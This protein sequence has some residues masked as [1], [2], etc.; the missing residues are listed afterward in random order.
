[1]R[2]TNYSSTRIRHR[3]PARRLPHRLALFC[4]ALGTLAACDSASAPSAPDEGLEAGP[5]A[6]QA[7]ASAPT[8]GSFAGKIAFTASDG[9]QRD[10]YVMNADGSGL[11]R[12][13]STPQNEFDPAWSWD[14]GRIAF[15]RPRTN[16]SA[17]VHGDVFVVDANGANGHWASPTPSAVSLRSPAWA[18]DGSR[19]L[20]SSSNGVLSMDLATGTLT[21]FKNGANNVSGLSMAFDATGQKVVVGTSGIFIYKADGSGQ[22]GSAFATPHNTAAE[23][24]AFSPDGKTVVLTEAITSD[25]RKIYLFSGSAFT[26]VTG[27]GVGLGVSWSPD[28]KQIV[29]G[30]RR[31]RVNRINADGSQRVGLAGTGGFDNQPAYSH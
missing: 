3:R 11:T 18:P 12:L 1:M 17:Q 31:G 6:D 25:R 15:I 10:I 28:G 9:V 23:S 24:V 22:I 4:A 26:L 13:T 30:G 2:V 27:S 21:Q 8:P 7:T 16:A 19:L 5:V 20:V 29:F 14:N